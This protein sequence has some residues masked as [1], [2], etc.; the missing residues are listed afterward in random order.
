[1]AS[2]KSNAEQKNY[3]YTTPTH[4]LAGLLKCK[5]CQGSVVQISGRRGGYYG[6]INVKQK[7]CSNK[8]SVSKRRIEALIIDDLKEKF[9]TKRSVCDRVIE[10]CSYY[11]VYTNI[12]ALALLS[13][14]E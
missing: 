6:C 13:K 12:Q 10:D 14:E 11:V 3:L 4:L 9:L 1:M 5:L 7:I 8:L 2:E